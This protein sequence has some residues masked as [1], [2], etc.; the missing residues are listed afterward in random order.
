MKDLLIGLGLLCC[1]ALVFVIFGT[2]G[3]E[4]FVENPGS[5]EQAE[6]IEIGRVVFAEE[7]AGCHGRLARGTERGPDLIQPAYGPSFTSDARLRRAV[8]EGV[9]GR[10]GGVAMPANPHLAEYRLH[11]MITFLREMQRAKGIR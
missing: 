6:A 5:R 10:D 3:M 2:S 11:R 7:C 9:P 4:A 8:R 1:P